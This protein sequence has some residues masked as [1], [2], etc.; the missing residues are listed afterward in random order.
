VRTLEIDGHNLEEIDRAYTQAEA[1][2]SSDQPT[3]IVARTIKGKGAKLVENQT[4][5]RQSDVP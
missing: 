5:A 2:A 4:V 1:V 3:M